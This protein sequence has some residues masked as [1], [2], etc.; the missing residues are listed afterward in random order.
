VDQLG[1]TRLLTDSSGNVA[2]RYDYLPFGEEIPADGI[3]RTTGMGYQSSA[4][5]FNPKFTGQVRD[6]ESGLDYFNARYYSPE[7]GRFVSVDPQ[8]AGSDPTNPQTWNGYA[9]V[10]GNPMLYTDP[11]GQGWLSDLGFG[12]LAGGVALLDFLDPAFLAV[13]PWQFG[14]INAGIAFGSGYGVARAAEAAANG[15][16]VWGM[17]L[18]GVSAGDLIGGSGEGPWSESPVDYFDKQAGP[19]LEAPA[20]SGSPSIIPVFKAQGTGCRILDPTQEAIE[21]KLKIG[22]EVQIGPFKFGGSLYKNMS[23]G[24]T[25]TTMEIS[26]WLASLQADNVTPK[27]GS[28]TGGGPKNITPSASFLFRQYD[29]RSG[30]LTWNPAKSFTFGFQALFGLEIS[31]NPETYDR[32]IRMNRACRGD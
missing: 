20:A 2:R 8:N 26:A 32:V 30:R 23:T 15:G 11:S 17:F 28:I 18:G 27:G 4:D 25:G 24:E 6:L 21:F 12:L 16:N 1:S 10:A 9:Y 19:A 31:F 14:A 22:P 5:G 13:T 29:V 7:Q 3:V